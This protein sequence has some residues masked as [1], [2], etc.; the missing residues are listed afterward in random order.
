MVLMIVVSTFSG[1]AGVSA[2]LSSSGLPRWEDLGEWMMG[3]RPAS[4]DMYT[5]L[6]TRGTFHVSSEVNV[7]LIIFDTLTGRRL[8]KKV[9]YPTVS[10]STFLLGC[11]VFFIFQDVCVAANIEE[12]YM[13]LYSSSDS[14]PESE[15]G[16]GYLIF[17]GIAI[18]FQITGAAATSYL[19]WLVAWGMLLPPLWK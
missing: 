12:W 9:T 10:L 16:R 19:M 4:K 3:Q 6:K 15:P 2:V 14:K 8:S 1:V 18:L 13:L 7:L 5:T 17:L 11:A